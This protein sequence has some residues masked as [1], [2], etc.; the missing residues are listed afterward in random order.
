[1]VAKLE[2]EGADL[3]V[4][5]SSLTARFY[6]D[7][8]EGGF[9]RARSLLEEALRDPDFAGFLLGTSEGETEHELDVMRISGDAFK[10]A[11]K[12]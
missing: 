10:D 12:G 7:K 2:A 3:Q 6:G 9:L 1:M 11:R 8:R 5:H 4:W